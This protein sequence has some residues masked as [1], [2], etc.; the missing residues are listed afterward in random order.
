MFSLP[1]LPYDYS[2]LEPWIDGETM[3][4]H[5]DKHHQTYVDNL[6]KILEGHA[7]LLAM[8]GAQFISNLDK[9][10]EEIRTKVHNN[11]G[12]VLNHNFFWQIMCSAKDS[13][14]AMKQFSNS[15]LAKE[16]EQTFGSL[17]NFQEKFSATALGRFGSGWAWLTVNAN[18]KLEV[19]DTPNQDSPIMDG[20]DPI[21]CLDVWKHAYYL[22]Y[23][24]RRKDYIDAW[25]NVVNWKEVEN[26]FQ[27]ATSV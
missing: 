14:A 23:Q 26:R 24:N 20:K 5:H 3:H 6:N 8:H 16:I 25:W 19:S 18:N 17:T 4:I 1:P 11:L 21:L 13:T 22:K 9:V 7:D 10:P 2:A 15:T 12:G 27:E